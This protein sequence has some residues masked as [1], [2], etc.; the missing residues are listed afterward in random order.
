MFTTFYL[1]NFFS[2]SYEEVIENK[3]RQRSTLGW[4]SNRYQILLNLKI[5]AT[6]AAASFSQLKSLI[7]TKS[8]EIG[9]L[10]EKIEEAIGC[11][12]QNKDISHFKNEV[13]N[14]FALIKTG[15]QE[16]SAVDKSFSICNLITNSIVSVIATAGLGVS[17]FMISTGPIGMIALGVGLVFISTALVLLAAYSLYVDGRFLANKQVKE[18]D[19]FLDKLFSK[20]APRQSHEN[21]IDPEQN[22]G[23]AQI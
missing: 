2:K 15:L 11:A 22:K 20:C 19:L 1:P 12:M 6:N 14:S 7:P 21:Q 16:D 9:T 4:D 5:E 17:C 13:T 8:I 10:E 18:I 23:L 3:L